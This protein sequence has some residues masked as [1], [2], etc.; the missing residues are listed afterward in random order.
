[1][2]ILSMFQESL[3][4]KNIPL[5]VITHTP[6]ETLPLRV[7]SLL[8]EIKADHLFANI[9]HEVDELRRDITVCDMAKETGV[10]CTFV[11]DKCII[12]PGTVKTKDDRAY[13]VRY[14]PVLRNNISTCFR[15]IHLFCELGYLTLSPRATIPLHA[16][17]LY[18]TMTWM[19]VTIRCSANGSNKSFLKP[20]KVLNWTQRMQKPFIRAGRLEKQLQERYF[21]CLQYFGTRI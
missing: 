20:W 18:M 5:F 4:E 16:L 10:K 9:E 13:T 3:A 17:P 8:S 11:H 12:V 1:M 15:C 2:L 7:V 19:L 6:R 14:V 21:L